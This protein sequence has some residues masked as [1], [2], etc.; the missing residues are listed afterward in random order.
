MSNKIQ[1]HYIHMNIAENFLLEYKNLKFN[2][3]EQKE[4]LPENIVTIHGVNA[5]R[6]CLDSENKNQCTQVESKEE[7]IIYRRQDNEFTFLG[8]IEK[9]E[10]RNAIMTLVKYIKNNVIYL[11]YP[12][13]NSQLNPF[14][15]GYVKYDDKHF[16][17][18]YNI[19]YIGFS[20]NVIALLNVNPGSID[21]A[22][23]VH[24]LIYVKFNFGD[25]VINAKPILVTSGMTQF[26]DLLS[27]M[28]IKKSVVNSSKFEV[29]IEAIKKCSQNS[30]K[31][32]KEDFN[33]IKN[34]L[35]IVGGPESNIWNYR[36]LVQILLESN[37]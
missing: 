27:L 10:P 36:I 12:A 32:G 16:I 9:S 18:E 6:D 29:A 24:P 14:T 22:M 5:M 8:I 11:Y 33:K 31:C 30:D 37:L 1:L 15:Y 19:S 23:D 26:K 34:I 13:I 20:V 35:D 2:L 21:I 25:Q 7:T 17:I 4:S 28:I 3:S